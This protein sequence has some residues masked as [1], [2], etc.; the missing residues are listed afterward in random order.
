MRKRSLNGA[1]DFRIELTSLVDIMFLLILFLV[2]TTTFTVSQGKFNVKLPGAV[3]STSQTQQNKVLTIIV[4]S[5]DDVYLGDKKVGLEG[6]LTSVSQYVQQN[7]TPT[8]VYL[9][10]DKDARYG[11]IVKVMDVLRMQKVFNINLIVKK[12]Q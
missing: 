11:I 6:L 2:L 10:A 3:T 8:A 4:T 7:G 1:E 9:K 12:L 5:N